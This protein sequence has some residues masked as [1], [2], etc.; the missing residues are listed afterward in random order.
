VFHSGDDGL[1]A[2]MKNWAIARKKYGE[3]SALIANI[4]I[5]VRHG[6]NIEFR[7]TISPM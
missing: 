6:E 3:Q 7:N 1:P 2:A 5:R 4:R